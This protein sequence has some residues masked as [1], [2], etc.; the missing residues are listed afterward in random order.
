LTQ[1]LPVASHEEA[2]QVAVAMAAAAI[3]EDSVMFEQL[4]DARAMSTYC[5]SH[6]RALELQLALSVDWHVADASKLDSEY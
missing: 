1:L 5:P 4:E 3:V 6:A 2:S